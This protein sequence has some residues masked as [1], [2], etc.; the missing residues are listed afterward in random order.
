MFGRLK[1]FLRMGTSWFSASSHWKIHD[2]RHRCLEG[3][4]QH[5]PST[6]PHGDGNP[7][8]MFAVNRFRWDYLPGK[9]RPWVQRDGNVHVYVVMPLSW[10]ISYLWH[11]AGQC[12]RI[13]GATCSFAYIHIWICAMGRLST[14]AWNQWW[15]IGSWIA[16][17]IKTG[18]MVK[19]E[20]KER[21]REALFQRYSR[22]LGLGWFINFWTVLFLTDRELQWCASLRPG[23]WQGWL[24]RRQNSPLQTTVS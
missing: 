18:V 9:S 17:S 1:D 3:I 13:A 8:K 12:W 14:A 10:S 24:L 11:L 7:V 15:I 6:S 22:I 20:K 19:K 2:N 21:S 23:D 5:R 16:S 4:N